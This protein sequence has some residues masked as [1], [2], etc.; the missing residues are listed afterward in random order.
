MSLKNDKKCV[1]ITKEMWAKNNLPPA[2]VN[3]Q[4][5]V[6][7]LALGKDWR[8]IGGVAGVLMRI[9]KIYAVFLKFS[10]LTD[11]EERNFICISTFP[12]KKAREEFLAEW[13]DTFHV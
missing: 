10:A 5:S 12:S 7:L 3:A 13:G 4:R 2:H 9:F 8:Q 1:T 11:L 6:V